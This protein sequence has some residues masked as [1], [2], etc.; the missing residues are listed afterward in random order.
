LKAPANSIILGNGRATDSSSSDG[1][2]V[3]P[4]MRRLVRLIGRG[5]GVSQRSGEEQLCQVV[6]AKETT[7]TEK[8]DNRPSDGRAAWA[9]L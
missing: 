6:T 8:H 2:K 4:R 3:G 9:K 1:R 5:I 7:D